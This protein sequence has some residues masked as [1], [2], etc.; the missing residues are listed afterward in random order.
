MHLRS[1]MDASA[2]FERELSSR[3]LTSINMAGDAV[4]FMY[5]FAGRGF[6]ENMW[7]TRHLY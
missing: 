3:G 4:V 2:F 1:D 6:L 5:E 7:R